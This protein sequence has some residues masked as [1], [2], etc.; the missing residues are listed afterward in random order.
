[1]PKPTNN[2]PLC[3]MFTDE[4]R[5]ALMSALIDASTASMGVDE[6]GNTD[7]Y[8]YLEDTPKTSLISELV[9]HLNRLGYRITKSHA[10]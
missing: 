6:D 2:K 3:T 4:E 10:N 9:E 7:V 8:G 1:M 5:N